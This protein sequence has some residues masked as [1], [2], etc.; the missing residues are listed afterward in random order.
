[1]KEED[2]ERVSGVS[3]YHERMWIERDDQDKIKQVYDGELKPIETMMLYRSFECETQENGFLY[4]GEFIELENAREYA[5]KRSQGYQRRN[6]G[7]TRE[8]VL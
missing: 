4:K 1:M 5:R 7:H 6:Y 3:R 8:E 2:L